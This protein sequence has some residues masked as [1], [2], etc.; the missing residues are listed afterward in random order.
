MSAVQIQINAAPPIIDRLE[1]DEIK[2]RFERYGLTKQ[3]ARTYTGALLKLCEAMKVTPE[4]LLEGSTPLTEVELN[5]VE[6]L[7]EDFILDHRKILAPK[8]LN[9]IFN[10]VKTWLFVNRKIKSRKLFK[11]IKFDKSSLKESAL[12][13]ES[14]TTTDVK[15]TFQQA[16]GTESVV[17]AFYGLMSLRPSLIP[18]LRVKHIHLRSKELITTPTGVTIKLKRP[19]LVIVPAKDEQGEWVRGNK[20]HID[21]MTFIP[22]RIT[23]L[24]ELNLNR[25]PAKTDN[26]MELKRLTCA[27]NKRDVRYIVK[28]YFK[29]IGKEDM[30]PY[31]LRNYADYILDRNLRE[32]EDLKEFLMGH[33][34]KISS[35]YQFRGLAPEKEDEFRRLYMKVDR[36]IDE[37]IFGAL[38]ETDRKI[39]VA[40]AM[41]A[42]TLGVPKEK[43]AEIMKLLDAGK[44]TLEQFNKAIAI[45]I[46]QSYREQI[47]D[48]IKKIIKEEIK[49]NG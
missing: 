22:S 20:A 3:S 32:D 1:K 12:M 34:G 45:Q 29:L 6:N 24:V 41:L 10:A 46:Q 13:T 23:E 47:K 18:F 27:D 49:N 9:V 33:K 16:N 2:R 19:C 14:I 39:A 35:V 26:D 31:R 7:T 36:F 21:F 38:S 43:V 25:E 37:S 4:N 48:E 28:K 44:I 40:Q 15:T 11:E 5:R 30:S 17:I 42:E 8:Y